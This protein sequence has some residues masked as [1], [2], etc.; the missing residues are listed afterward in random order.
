[1]PCAQARFQDAQI[2]SP[3]E[4]V[5]ILF[6]EVMPQVPVLDTQRIL[7]EYKDVAM[8]WGSR[9]LYDGS[10]KHIAQVVRRNLDR[11]SREEGFQCFV[12]RLLKR[13]KCARVGALHGPGEGFVPIRL[14]RDAG[15]VYA[16]GN[17]LFE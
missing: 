7:E 3:K 15:R 1:M 8:S 10:E 14:W 4:A 17:T 9:H 16:C 2:S 5:R 12:I 6:K 11:I 13:D